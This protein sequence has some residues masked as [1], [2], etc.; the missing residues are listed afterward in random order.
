[1][2]ATEDDVYFVSDQSTLVKV[3]TK[4]LFAAIKGKNKQEMLRSESVV[5]KDAETISFDA[6]SKSV[7]VLSSAGV[8][9]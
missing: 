1:M 8:L 9:F 4:R 6:V 5:C 7:T 3:D 2:E